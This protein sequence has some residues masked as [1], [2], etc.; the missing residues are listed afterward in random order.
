ME[1]TAVVRRIKKIKR[2]RCWYGGMVLSKI[3]PKNPRKK[4]NKG[5]WVWCK[6]EGK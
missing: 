4:G 2:L 3:K 1:Q 5:G 6:E